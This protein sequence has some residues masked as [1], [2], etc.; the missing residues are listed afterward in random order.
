MDF[1]V[2]SYSRSG[3][4]AVLGDMLAEKLRCTHERLE[5]GRISV[6]AAGLSSLLG[7]KRKVTPIDIDNK[8]V[9]LCTPAWIGRLPAPMRGFLE[10]HAINEY[11]LASVSGSGN[12]KQMI[13]MVADLAGK[14]PEAVVEFAADTKNI[15]TVLSRE[16]VQQRF[17]VQIDRFVA[18]L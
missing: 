9:V 3:N 1:L 5:A 7:L 8:Y 18:S 6:L 10:Q 17:G 14:R 11:A 13:D 2:V 12:N 15:G 16:D 4:N